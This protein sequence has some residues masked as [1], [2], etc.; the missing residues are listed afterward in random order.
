MRIET[1]RRRGFWAAV[2]VAF[3]LAW[4]APSRLGAQSDAGPP[5]EIKARDNVVVLLDASGSMREIMRGSKYSR[6]RN[7]KA[8]LEKVVSQLPPETNIGLLVFSGV[9]SRRQP[10][11][12]DWLYP[13]RTLDTGEFSTALR[14]PQ[15][16][17][18]TP[19]GKYLKKAADRLLKERA[20]QN[21]YGTFRLLVV[22]DGNATDKQLMRRTIPKILARGIL[23]DAIGVDM[24]QRHELAKDAHSYRS[25]NDPESL[26]RAL[27]EIFAEVGS[28]RD[29]QATDEAFELLEGLPDDVASGV[30]AALA[31]VDNVPI[32]ERPTQAVPRVK[33]SSS[34]S[35]RSPSS[36][37]TTYGSQGRTV[38]VH[39]PKPH[40]S[41]PKLPFLII[42][43]IIGGIVGL[44]RKS[45]Q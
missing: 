41:V 27:A 12:D 29:Q 6:M 13:L 2:A 3:A 8:A 1:C 17:G 20:A 22:T 21:G 24:E 19:L 34:P 37:R 26:E 11:R 44:I 38:I 14:K 28:A 31:R 39:D 10:L 30:L 43:A 7:A 25:A 42:V 5:N 15:P 4:T 35:S 40:Y 33:R 16:G 32:G 9:D 45:M 18:Q 23:V 36:T